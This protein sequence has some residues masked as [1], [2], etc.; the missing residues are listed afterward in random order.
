MCLCASLKGSPYVTVNLNKQYHHNIL[1]IGT[2][3]VLDFLR[4]V[5][6]LDVRVKLYDSTRL[7]VNYE[8]CYLFSAA[9]SPMYLYGKITTKLDIHVDDILWSVW[10]QRF[11]THASC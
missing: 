8:N 9:F 1:I 2:E 4:P 3:G 10:L 11:W 5:S 7:D 6:V